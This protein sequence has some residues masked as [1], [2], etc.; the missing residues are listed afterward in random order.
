VKFEK[1]LRR[2]ITFRMG[3]AFREAALLWLVFSLLDRLVEGKL[4]TPWVT[5]NLC[6]S[7]AWWL[8]GIYFER[9]KTDG[10]PE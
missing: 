8:F 6:G 2:L 1:R 5:W 3:E 9:G 7:V 4:T 10:H